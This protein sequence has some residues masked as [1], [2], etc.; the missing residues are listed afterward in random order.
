M[1]IHSAA[2]I[3]RNIHWAQPQQM[4]RVT[5]P[6]D[7]PGYLTVGADLVSSSSFLGC[8]AVFRRSL[9]QANLACFNEIYQNVND[10]VFRDK[11]ESRDYQGKR[12]NPPYGPSN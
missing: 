12:V 1:N 3:T 8:I 5:A 10:L 6:N 11:V 4:L 7:S 9:F 2:T